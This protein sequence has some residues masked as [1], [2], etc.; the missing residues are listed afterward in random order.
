MLS[1]R[2]TR[3]LTWLLCLSALA[4]SSARAQDPASL[5]KVALL[6]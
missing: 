2:L 3:I 4:V 6:A 5:V 1:L